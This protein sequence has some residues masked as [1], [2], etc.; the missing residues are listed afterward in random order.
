MG[1]LAPAFTDLNPAVPGGEQANG[2]WVHLDGDDFL[3]TWRAPFYNRNDAGQVEAQLRLT[4]PNTIDFNYRQIPGGGLVISAGLEDS[5]ALDG[6][7][8][9]YGT[10]E[11]PVNNYAVHWTYAPQDVNHAPEIV[12]L[13][14]HAGLTGVLVQFTVE[15]VDEDAD[16]LTYSMSPLEGAE[17]NAATGLFRWTPEPN[18]QGD[19]QVTFTVMDDGV[20]PLS[21]EQTITISIDRP[22][23]P[24]EVTS[25]P[26]TTAG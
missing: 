11:N 16:R 5:D 21:D 1:M 19:H 4:G 3:V 9:F 6:V 20:P 18:Q 22:N 14:D 23:G 25:Q 15:A 12:N 7:S 17:F 10:I 24:P 26:P 13:E 8:S 2:V